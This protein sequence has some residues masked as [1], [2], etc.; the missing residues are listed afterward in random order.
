M[1]QFPNPLLMAPK[2]PWRRFRGH[3]W[4]VLGRSG[5]SSGLP[6]TFIPYSTS[7]K[8]NDFK[9]SYFADHLGG[10]F[11]AFWSGWRRLGDLLWKPFVSPLSTLIGV[12]SQKIRFCLVRLACLGLFHAKA[13]FLGFLGDVLGRLLTIV[14]GVSRC[15]CDLCA[16]VSLT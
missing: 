10:A 5:R 1:C 7:L 8:N 2:A 16:G 3:F 4:Q 11:G 6:K 9:V 14:T 12:H 13:T 15:S